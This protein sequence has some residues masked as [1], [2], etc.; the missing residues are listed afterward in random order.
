MSM[1]GFLAHILILLGPTRAKQL[2]TNAIAT[3]FQQ[4]CPLSCSRPRRHMH[5][6][7][8]ITLMCLGHVILMMNFAGILYLSPSENKV[9]CPFPPPSLPLLNILFVSPSFFSSLTLTFTLFLSLSLSLSL[10]P[11]LTPSFLYI[12]RHLLA[13][14]LPLTLLASH[15]VYI[16]SHPLIQSTS[17][18]PPLHRP[19]FLCSSPSLFH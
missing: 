10:F 11:S 16:F 9:N 13:F 12:I 17:R 18:G 1:Q 6:L 19:R 8:L 4:L 15:S 2:F 14:H 5:T 3:D 7:L